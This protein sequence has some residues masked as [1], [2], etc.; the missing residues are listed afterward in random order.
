MSTAPNMFGGA[1]E[2]TTDGIEIDGVVRRGRR[3]YVLTPTNSNDSINLPSALTLKPGG[4]TFILVNTHASW[5]IVVNDAS[6]SALGTISAESGVIFNLIDNS[7]ASGVWETTQNLSY[8]EASAIT[9]FVATFEVSINADTDR[10]NARALVDALGFDGTST[11]DVT[12]TIESGFE[13]YSTTTSVGA[14]TFGTFPAG[15]QVRL[16]NKGTISG[17]GGGGGYGGGGS[18]LGPAWTT[19]PSTDG[20]DGGTALE[21]DAPGTV[22]VYVNNTVG[23][24]RGGGGGGGGGGL[25]NTSPNQGL[26]GGGGG[27]QGRGAWA[28][29]YFTPGRRGYVAAEA[30]S[31]SSAGA[32]GTGGVVARGGGSPISEGTDGG[33]G[34]SWGSA[35]TSGETDSGTGSPYGDGASGGAAGHAVTGNSGITWEGTGTRTGTIA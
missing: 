33:A 11:A 3:V 2:L 18:G 29:G 10:V 16:I 1:L 6:G 35:G 17:A 23:T 20:F 4:P 24:I 25:I 30:G 8:S 31:V 22:A 12:I 34:G 15:S 27:G 28:G 26:G 9:G 13:V 7:E 32:A 5:G 14:F 21:N 19:I